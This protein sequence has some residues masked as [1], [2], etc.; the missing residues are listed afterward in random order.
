MADVATAAVKYLFLDVVG[1]TKDRSVE[2]QTEIVVALNDA[3]RGALSDLGIAAE[4]TILIPTGDGVCIALV[5]VEDPFD[6]QILL[7]AAILK[8]LTDHNDSQSDVMRRFE[9]RIGLNE[10]IDNL[11]TDIN[12]NRNVAG[13]GISFA[14][15]VMDLADERQVLVSQAVYDRLRHRERYMKAFRAMRAQLKHGESIAVYQVVDD[16]FGVNADVPRALRPPVKKQERLPKDVA[17]YLGHAIREREALLR[18]R[19]SFEAVTAGVVLWLRALDTVRELESSEIDEPHY[20]AHGGPN[21]SF[22]EQ[23]AYYSRVPWEVA[24]LLARDGIA[25][26]LWPWSDLF[27]DSLALGP[28]RFVNDAGVAKLRNEWPDIWKRMQLG[29][30]A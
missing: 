30:A 10:N 17:C 8:R 9:V 21:A 2:A 19:D 25:R 5:G 29:P 13:A 11:I 16:T 1:F 22:D 26:H 4:A 7:A 3:V 24:S 27:E 23:F 28:G 20:S 18:H 6:V 15:R 12:G 14:A